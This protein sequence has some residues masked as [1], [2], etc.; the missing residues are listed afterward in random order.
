VRYGSFYPDRI[1]TAMSAGEACLFLSPH[2]DDVILSCGAL[3]ATLGQSC[4]VTVA[5]IFTAAGPKPHTFAARSFLQKCSIA[6]ADTLFA[7]R[8]AEDREVLAGLGV[9]HVHLGAT[10]A[11]FRSREPITP[12]AR[13]VGRL[14][15][16]LVHRYPTYWF[17][18]ARGRLARGD[19]P[20]VA[21]LNA[22]VSELLTSTNATLLFCPMAVGRH[23][24]HIIARS[25]GAQHPHQVVYYSDFPYSESYAPDRSFIRTNQLVPWTWEARIAEKVQLIRGYRTQANL[26]FPSGHVPAVPE[27]Y[28]CPAP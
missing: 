6:D 7:Q 20:L 9:G 1:A 8:R 17:D 14:F 4:A 24:D 18:I 19:R 5:T 10:D 15:P 22:R 23:V 26:L 2:L 16:E 11:L 21:S 12:M 13:H 28:Y 3:I 25:I 27:T